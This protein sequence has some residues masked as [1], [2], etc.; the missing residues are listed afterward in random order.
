MLVVRFV[1]HGC[2]SGMLV[3]NLSYNHVTRYVCYGVMFNKKQARSTT[4]QLL[5]SLP[6]SLML[7]FSSHQRN[8]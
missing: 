1:C 6:V 4:V 3:V 2:P 8:N 5:Y 7:H